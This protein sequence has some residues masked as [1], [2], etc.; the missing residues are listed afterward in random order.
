[1][2]MRRNRPAPPAPGC[3]DPAPPGR[4]APGAQHPPAGSARWRGVKDATAHEVAGRHFVVARVQFWVSNL[5]TLPNALLAV[6]AKALDRD[7]LRGPD[8]PTFTGI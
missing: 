6:S 8:S 1:M 2:T 5:S 7:A 3:P 4:A